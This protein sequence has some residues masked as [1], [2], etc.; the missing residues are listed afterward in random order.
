M[1]KLFYQLF[2]LC[3]FI[4]IASISLSYAGGPDSQGSDM[5]DAY[6]AVEE[7]F[8]WLQ[9][10]A[11]ATMVTVATKTEKRLEEAPGNVT[12][13]TKEKLSRHNIKTA[14]EALSLLTSVFVKRNKGLMDSSASVRLRGFNKDQYTLILLDGQPLNNGYIG[15]LSWNALPVENIERIELIRGAASALYGGNAMGGVINI[16]TQTPEK[17][18][19]SATV[20]YGTHDTQRYRA[21]IGHRLMDKVSMRV[22][23]EAELTDGYETTPVIRTIKSGEGSVS[24]GRPMNDEF[25]SATKWMVGDRGKTMPKRGVSMQKRVLISPIPVCSPLP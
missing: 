5:S 10:E 15:G 16:I 2:A 17:P 6:A 24:G 13:I 11:E 4:L 14:D 19:A 12:V 25:G 21:H 22:G 8:R 3:V 1:K 23:Y 9:E 7:E 18:E 20:G